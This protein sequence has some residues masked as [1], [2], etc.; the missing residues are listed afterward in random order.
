MTQGVTARARQRPC[1]VTR[2]RTV[3]RRHLANAPE[4]GHVGPDRVAPPGGEIA[5][6]ER[7][8]APHVG[9]SEHL[10]EGL[11]EE[12]VGAA[13]LAEARWL[14][15][16]ELV[17]GIDLDRPVE[18]LA[19]DRREVGAVVAV[20]AVVD[21]VEVVRRELDRGLAIG[22]IVGGKRPGEDVV[23]RLARLAVDDR[24]LVAHVEASLV[25]LE[26]R[27]EDRVLVQVHE[28]PFADRV[29]EVAPPVG[30][31]DLLG[32]EPPGLLPVLGPEDV[33]GSEP[34]SRGGGE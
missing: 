20:A 25:R 18:A 4:R 31:E 21:R 32:P 27:R 29:A 15:L 28:L 24:A 3:R 16:V 6:A 33:T 17:E 2:W 14:P 11:L 1:A 12:I 22:W 9:R 23:R 10:R 13:V 19:V 34:G 26:R 5:P 30:I 7:E 8:R